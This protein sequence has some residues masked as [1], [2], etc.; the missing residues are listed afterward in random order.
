MRIT[1]L[2]RNHNNTHLLLSKSC[3]HNG[4]LVFQLSEVVVVADGAC[5]K[6]SKRFSDFR[7]NS[8]CYNHGKNMHVK[9]EEKSLCNFSCSLKEVCTENTPL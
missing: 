3:R 7:T 1:A 6:N 5:E 4:F 8:E 9:C 2:T